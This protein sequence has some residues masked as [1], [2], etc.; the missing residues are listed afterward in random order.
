LAP[1]WLRITESRRIFKTSV[2]STAER[3]TDFIFSGFYPKLLSLALASVSAPNSDMNGM[4]IAPITAV[5]REQYLQAAHYGSLADHC[6]LAVACHKY[7]YQ[8]HQSALSMGLDDEKI[9]KP[10]QEEQEQEK[11][12]LSKRQQMR[13]PMNSRAKNGNSSNMRIR[14]SR[15]PLVFQSRI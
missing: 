15:A 5:L 6:L 4:G 3:S 9:I 1:S 8:S 13:Q 11:H 7:S 10:Y 2:L 14:T 12:C